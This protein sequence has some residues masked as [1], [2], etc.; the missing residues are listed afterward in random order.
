MLT[1]LGHSPG[2]L[3]FGLV[4]P[5]GAALTGRGAWRTASPARATRAGLVYIVL[6]T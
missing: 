5:H 4:V 3:D 1:D 6:A 2:D